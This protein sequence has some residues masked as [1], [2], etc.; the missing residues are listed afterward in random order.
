VSQW[1]RKRVEEIFRWLKVVGLLPG[2]AVEVS[3]A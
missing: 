3:G 2:R 1:K